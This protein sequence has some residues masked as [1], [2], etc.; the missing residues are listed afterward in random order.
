MFLPIFM[1]AKDYMKIRARIIVGAAFAVA[2]VLLLIKQFSPG[3]HEKSEI[4]EVQEIADVVEIDNKEEAEDS[5]ESTAVPVDFDALRKINPDIV[6]W[7]IVEGTEISY[8]IMQSSEDEEE[9]FYLHHSFRRESSSHG[10][11]YIQKVN[12]ADFS[13]F[14]TVIYGHNMRDGT[15][16][17]QLHL[18]RN[19][20]FFDENDEITVYTPEGIYHYRIFAAYVTENEM[21]LDTWGNFENDVLKE[22][23]IES[24]QVAGGNQRD[25]EITVDSQIIT[26]STCC[27]DDTKRLLVQGVEII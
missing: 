24:L 25:A 19:K 26:L 16:F 11:I 21:I 13:D 20:D 3:W 22:N 12:N 27:G 10:S 17:R 18:F 6:G 2:G 5:G 9:D 1:E 14:N 23:Y 15:M 4:K 7:I 8:P